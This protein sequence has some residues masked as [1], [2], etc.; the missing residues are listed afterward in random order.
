M[1]P[2]LKSAF[3]QRA[4][5]FVEHW[6]IRQNYRV[7]PRSIAIFLEDPARRAKFLTLSGRLPHQCPKPDTIRGWGPSPAAIKADPMHPDHVPYLTGTIRT[8]ALR[9][10]R[11]KQILDLVAQG[12][13]QLAIAKQLNLS[14]GQVHYAIHNIPPSP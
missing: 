6:C 9:H 14:A 5:K 13:S 12:H 4:L 11:R 7:G 1:A 2:R 8:K 10:L 3:N